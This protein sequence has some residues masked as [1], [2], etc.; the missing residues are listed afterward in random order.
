M[1]RLSIA[2]MLLMTWSGCH[3]GNSRVGPL[4]Q[5]LPQV[6]QTDGR[7]LG[8]PVC[9]GVA[10]TG[11]AG[12]DRSRLRTLSLRDLVQ[13]M[14]GALDSL[15]AKGAV[16]SELVLDLIRQLLS[17]GDFASAEH[18]FA[19]A[20]NACHLDFDPVLVGALRRR[21]FLTAFQLLS[22]GTGVPSYLKRARPSVV[23]LAEFEAEAMAPSFGKAELLVAIASSWAEHGRTTDAKRALESALTCSVQ[24]PPASEKTVIVSEAAIVRNH[25]G[26]QASAIRL[27]QDLEREHD[28]RP[29]L[30][31]PGFVL[32]RLA[33]AFASVGRAMGAERLFLR[34]A[35]EV[36]CAGPV[37]RARSLRWLAIH[38]A[39]AGRL[40]AALRSARAVS[41]LDV[42]DSDDGAAAIFEVGK[43][44]LRFGR[45][46]TALDAA[47][48]R[49]LRDHVYRDRLL[50]EIAVNVAAR[51]TASALPIANL[52]KCKSFSAEA[53]LR[54]AHCAGLAGRTELAA[55]VADRCAGLLVH[56]SSEGI[57]KRFSLSRPETWITRYEAT[58]DYSSGAAGLWREAAERVAGAATALNCTLGV[59][60]DSVLGSALKIARAEMIRVVARAHAASTGS[61]GPVSWISLL[62]GEEVRAWGLAGTIEGMLAFE[63]E[64]PPKCE[65]ADGPF[66]PR[67]VETPRPR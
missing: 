13:L 62:A 24:M 52:I 54:V 30:T 39:R 53:L 27:L 65:E 35:D 4:P 8:A 51:D 66:A 64:S 16:P 56:T 36:I 1:I 14:A 31:L 47:L 21:E 25:I 60:D 42:L 34:A 2:L 26:D 48:S 46:A 58:V 67:D 28:D 33:V 7:S 23:T 5:A 17:A 19:A 55:G 41:E 40:D 49:E 10:L 18:V 44:S 32:G 61:S 63:A 50:V 20:G 37:H 22:G 59:A 29:D 15:S 12:A 43:Q 45:L 57:S 38:E 9:E 3:L 6:A 11:F